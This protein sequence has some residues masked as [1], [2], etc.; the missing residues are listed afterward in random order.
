MEENNLSYRT[1]RSVTS[2]FLAIVVPK[3]NEVD[4]YLDFIYLGNRIHSSVGRCTKLLISGS[5]VRIAVDAL[6]KFGTSD[7]IG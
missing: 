2:K 5:C 3:I 4:D 7:V 1:V 6:D